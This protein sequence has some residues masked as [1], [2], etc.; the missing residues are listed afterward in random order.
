MNPKISA[1][2]A[3]QLEAFVDKVRDRLSDPRSQYFD[4]AIY[5]EWFE[6]FRGVVRELKELEPDLFEPLQLRELP[7]ASRTSD[8][9]GRGYLTRPPFETLSNDIHLALKIIGHNTPR[10]GEATQS[11]LAAGQP[12]DAWKLLRTTISQ[13]T[14]EVL[15]Q[16]PYVDSYVLLMLESLA[17][18][19]PI[20][21]LTRKML[22]DFEA[23][24]RKFAQQHGQLE[25]RLTNEFH[26]RF[27]VIDGEYYLL[28]ASIKDAG[29]KACMFVKVGEPTIVTRLEEALTEAW[30]KGTVVV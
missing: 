24:A 16:D 7:E 28:G 6:E 23:V 13:A 15:I 26:D 25:V 9:E 12:F 1:V 21:I 5:L 8:N 18:K 10:P 2:R 20:R 30:E 17:G 22:G 4:P 3:P 29:T 14:S 27:L 11:F 19:I